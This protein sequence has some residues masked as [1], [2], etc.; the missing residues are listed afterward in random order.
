MFTEKL[1][2]ASL[3][4]FLI[5]ESIFN[6]LSNLDGRAY[7][8]VD[9]QGRLMVSSSSAAAIFEAGTHLVLDRGRVIAPADSDEVALNRVLAV[10]L[11]AAAAAEA[12]VLQ[13]DRPSDCITVRSTALSDAF[14][15]LVI[16]AAEC[17]RVPVLPSL[18]TLFGLTPCEER[19][20]QDLYKGRTPQWIAKDHNNSIHTIR[21]HI[22]RCYDKMG[23]G[24]REELWSKLNVYVVQ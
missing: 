1:T 4:A 8:L 13:G 14:V 12:V 5:I 16:T 22:R 15:C 19:I 9:R 6:C 10:G 2:S 11:A 3:D 24:C 23:V 18:E 21:A 7:L 20:V 17:S